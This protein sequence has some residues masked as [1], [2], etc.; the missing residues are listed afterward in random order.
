M[1]PVKLDNP[2][3]PHV[4]QPASRPALQYAS[5][6]TVVGTPAGDGRLSKPGQP[7]VRPECRKAPC[8]FRS[9]IAR[10][11]P[12]RPST[13]LRSAG[14]FCIPQFGHRASRESAFE[15]AGPVSVTA[16]RPHR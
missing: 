9:G 7:H 14:G 15:L 10:I 5:S 4:Y 3:H 2:L 8:S 1:V 16:V 13:A 6:F 11:R 12:G